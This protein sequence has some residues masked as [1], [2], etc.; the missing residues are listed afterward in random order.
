MELSKQN[1]SFLFEEN[2]PK[3]LLSCNNSHTTNV[4]I[5]HHPCLSMPLHRIALSQT[6][7]VNP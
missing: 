3:Q 5:L 2:S 1:V 4:D 6:T 7:N